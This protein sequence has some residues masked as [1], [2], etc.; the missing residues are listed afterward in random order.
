[1]APAAGPKPDAPANRAPQPV[2]ARHAGGESTPYP[3]ARC[4]FLRENVAPFGPGSAGGGGEVGNGGGGAG[5]EG[6]AG[7]P[8][9][10][11]GVAFAELGEQ[12]AVLLVGFGRRPDGDD[13]FEVAAG[14]APELVLEAQPGGREQQVGVVGVVLQP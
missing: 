13:G 2:G 14:L 4:S 1:P 8:G 3:Q 11:G 5:G 9:F 10:G 12:A 7:A 6:E